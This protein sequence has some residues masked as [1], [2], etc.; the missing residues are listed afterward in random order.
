VLIT[1]VVIALLI[2]NL[3]L[4]NIITLAAPIL[5]IICPPFMTTVILLL[6]RKHIKTS[7]VYKGAA[8]VAIAVS[9]F[10]TIN[11]LT[12]AL[13]WVTQAPL[14]EYGFSWLIPSAFGALLGGVLGPRLNASSPA[15]AETA[16]VEDVDE[17]A[18]LSYGKEYATSPSLRGE[19]GQAP[20]LEEK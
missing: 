13:P 1:V 16:L 15:R 4:S 20:S 17:V 19:E 7:W 18:E 8:I 12:G 11:D 9:V 14:Y 6:F 2:C 10:L 3:G 5:S